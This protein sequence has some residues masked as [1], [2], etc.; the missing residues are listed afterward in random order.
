MEKREEIARDL[1]RWYRLWRENDAMY[2]R[3]ARARGLSLNALMLLCALV[4][5]GPLTQRSASVALS[6]P[7]QTVNT[8]LREFERRRLIS[9]V[10]DEADRRNKRVELTAAGH[11]YADGLTGELHALELDIME[12]IGAGR[13]REMVDCMELYNSV[14]RGEGGGVDE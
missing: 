9:L 6:M 10:P 12:R 13:M 5:E 1:R 4:D 7:K 8:I 3:W 14:F 11:E 2:A